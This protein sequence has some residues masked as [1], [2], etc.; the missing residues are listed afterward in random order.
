MARC[1]QLRDRR[2]HVERIIHQRPSTW[3]GE[4]CQSTVREK[5]KRRSQPQVCLRRNRG[6]PWRLEPGRNVK[7][8]PE[9]FWSFAYQRQPSGSL[10][11]S[12]AYKR[13]GPTCVFQCKT[14]F[15]RGTW[16][17][18]AC[19]ETRPDGQ[20]ELRLRYQ[21][22]TTTLLTAALLDSLMGPKAS[23]ETLRTER[24][25]VDFARS[26]RS[27]RCP[28]IETWCLSWFRWTFPQEAVPSQPWSSSRQAK[29]RCQWF[30]VL[31]G[32]R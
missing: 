23:S 8:N 10:Q 2:S 14:H 7:S 9:S 22:L 21:V 11:A 1:S 15:F 13:K 5:G 3:A 4:S 19:V 30:R 16:A 28:S 25:Q 6:I 29:P 24:H 12:Q 32:S 27:Q 20:R 17:G 18:A 26:A 31:P